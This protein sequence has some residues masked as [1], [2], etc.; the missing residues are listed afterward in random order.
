MLHELTR[1]DKRVSLISSEE[2]IECRRC[3][4]CKAVKVDQQLTFSDSNS[5]YFQ[6]LDGSKVSRRA[7]TDLGTKNND[8][9]NRNSL[10]LWKLDEIKPNRKWWLRTKHIQHNVNE[11]NSEREFRIQCV[12]HERLKK[13]DENVQI[14]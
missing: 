9:W 14:D 10:K 7:K 11:R 6:R 5:S 3:S 12:T 8:W 4:E 1:Q 2:N 13:L